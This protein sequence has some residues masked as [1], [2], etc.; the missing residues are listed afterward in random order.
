MYKIGV[1]VIKRKKLCVFRWV[2]FD[3]EMDLEKYYCEYFMLFILWCNEEKDFIKIF[4]FFE[5]SF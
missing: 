5:E 3:K 2:Y 4:V 1:E